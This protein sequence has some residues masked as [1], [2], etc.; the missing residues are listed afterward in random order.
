MLV[1]HLFHTNLVV[2]GRSYNPR[3]KSY[4][5]TCCC[6]LVVI[7]AALSL[8]V[9]VAFTAT[10]ATYATGGAS[11]FSVGIEA[12]SA[13]LLTTDCADTS[14]KVFTISIFVC[15]GGCFTAFNRSARSIILVSSTYLML[16]RLLAQWYM[17]LASV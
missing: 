13:T 17:H 6:V 5:V 12:T 16:F 3:F 11:E 15:S 14:I 7:P 8:Y 1:L 10:H 4:A 9:F 2:L